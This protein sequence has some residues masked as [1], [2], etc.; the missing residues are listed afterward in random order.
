MPA[1]AMGALAASIAAALGRPR[2]VRAGI[3]GGVVSTGVLGYAGGLVVAP[4]QPKTGV[5]GRADADAGSRGVHGDSPAGRGV[6]GQATTGQG[7]SGQAATGTAGYFSTPKPLAGVHT[8]FALRAVG[9]VKLDR[10]AEIALIS[11]ASDRVTVSPGID[12]ASS[13]SVVATLQG[14]AGG[15]TVA[16]VAVNTSADSF[17]IIL[18]GP[19]TAASNIKVAWHAFG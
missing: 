12:L 16:G 3:D 14:D 1:A 8:G 2:S 15:A 11:P 19:S 5:Y 9:R 17:T 18:T 13:T 7:I 4:S 6:Y 10:C